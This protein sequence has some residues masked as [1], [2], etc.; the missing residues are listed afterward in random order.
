MSVQ[1]DF[2]SRTIDDP[3]LEEILRQPKEGRACQGDDIILLGGDEHA[4]ASPGSHM[5]PLLSTAASH[6][7]AL[8]REM[9]GSDS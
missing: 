4:A 9:A 5:L 1:A 8:E 2:V 3:M 6:G 7:A